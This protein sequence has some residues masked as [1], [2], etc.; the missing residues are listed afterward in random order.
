MLKKIIIT[1]LIALVI[2]AI[3]ITIGLNI[4]KIWVPKYKGTIITNVEEKESLKA[5]LVQT[6]YTYLEKKA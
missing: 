6:A 3:G 1:T 5:K 4:E 2:L